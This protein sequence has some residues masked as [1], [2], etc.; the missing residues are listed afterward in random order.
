M[1]RDQEAFLE[2]T[3]SLERITRESVTRDSFLDDLV[4][5]QE[6]TASS[7]VAQ[8]EEYCIF[9]RHIDVQG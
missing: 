2:E 8:S 6:Y 1:R 4:K 7:E 3:Q 9:E 5:Q